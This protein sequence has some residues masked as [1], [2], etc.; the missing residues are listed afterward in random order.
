MKREVE[1]EP[2]DDE[3]QGADPWDVL[4]GHERGRVRG[5][6]SWGCRGRVGGLRLER[7]REEGMG[8]GYTKHGA[9]THENQMKGRPDDSLG[10]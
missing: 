10:L 4:L 3:R 9:P 8:M 5:A 7:E 1:G 2:G 6:T